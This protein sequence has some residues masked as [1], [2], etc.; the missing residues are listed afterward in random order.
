MES[1]NTSLIIAPLR[2]H[3]DRVIKHRST[4]AEQMEEINNLIV[5]RSAALSNISNGFR[6]LMREI[7]ASFPEKSVW[8]KTLSEAEKCIKRF[9]GRG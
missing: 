2:S 9:D 3:L 4:Q 5:E 1:K 8:Q 7:P 6:K